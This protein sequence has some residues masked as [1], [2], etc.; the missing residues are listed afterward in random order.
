LSKL[1]EVP[2]ETEELL[3]VGTDTLLSLELEPLADRR[4]K[5][6]FLLEVGVEPDVLLVTAAGGITEFKLL[7]EPCSDAR[8]DV[9]LFLLEPDGLLEIWLDAAT[10]GIAAPAL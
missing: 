2:F 10:G 1:S 4:R 9:L 8:R 3:E 7:P 5:A 6:L